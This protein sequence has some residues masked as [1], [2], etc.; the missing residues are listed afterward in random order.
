MAWSDA[1][2][3]S[4]AA[5]GGFR[6]IRSADASNTD[7]NSTT[8][9]RNVMRYILIQITGSW[10]Q[11]PDNLAKA[12]KLVRE[13]F[14]GTQNKKPPESGLPK[15]IGGGYAAFGAILFFRR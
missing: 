4:S 11:Q 9:I 13:I 15:S 3:A 2:R 10:V 7:C 5:S 12:Q 1:R 8:V 6:L 14:A